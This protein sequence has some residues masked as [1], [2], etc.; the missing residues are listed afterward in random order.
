MIQK[1]RVFLKRTS[2]WFF[3]NQ[4]QQH[5]PTNIYIYIPKHKYIF[6]FHWNSIAD[7]EDYN[8][9]YSYNMMHFLNKY[10]RTFWITLKTMDSYNLIMFHRNRIEII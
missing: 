3:D 8:D 5:A 10:I 6:T 2:M 7:R 4:D 9:C 1:L